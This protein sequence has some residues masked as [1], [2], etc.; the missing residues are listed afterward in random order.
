MTVLKRFIGLVLSTIVLALFYT[1]ITTTVAIE[2]IIEWQ[3]ILMPMT[4]ALT[5]IYLALLVVEIVR[6]LHIVTKLVRI[7]VPSVHVTYSL[8]QPVRYTE[9]KVVYTPIQLQVI[10]C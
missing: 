10:R 5:V 9:V 7:Y 2:T 6:L 1:Y 8:Q 3:S 4:I